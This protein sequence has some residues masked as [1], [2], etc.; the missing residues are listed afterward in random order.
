MIEF[1]WLEGGRSVGLCVSS[2]QT[3]RANAEFGDQEQSPTPRQ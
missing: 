2:D 1:S 3:L